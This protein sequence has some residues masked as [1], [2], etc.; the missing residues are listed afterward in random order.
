MKKKT[1]WK[2]IRK[3]ITHSWGRFFSIMMLM[4]LGSFAL[5]GLLVTGPDMRTTGENY[6][7]QLNVADITIISDY[8]IDESEREYIEKA[9]GIRDIEYVYLKDVV[10]SDDINTSF[11]ICSKPHKISFYEMIEGRLPEEDNEIAID[12]HYGKNYSIGDTI[13]F[14]E[15]ADENGNE[16]L[17]FHDFKVVGYIKSG[18]I[19][20]NL[21]RGQTTAGSGELSSFGIVNENVFDSEVYMMAKVTF[22]DTTGVDPYS[23]EYTNLI[24][25][26][27]EKLSELLNDQ[28]DIRLASIKS[29]YQTEIDDGQTK[30]DDAKKELEDAR[31]TLN[32]AQIQINDAKT[33]IEENESKLADANQKIKNAEEEI[34]SNEATLIEKQSEYNSKKSEFSR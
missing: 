26:H 15:K 19:L 20:S 8:G 16:T 4:A 10:V 5:V 17:K 22:E 14:T 1:L 34:K 29:E 33:Q 6:F 7:N 12:E 21:N 25:A 32:D 23:D 24:S 18:E 31:T 2:D 30:I 11:R 9:S 28:Q 13:S 3:S 27:K